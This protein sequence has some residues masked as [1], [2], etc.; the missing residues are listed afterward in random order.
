MD[1]KPLLPKGSVIVTT[2]ET[3]DTDSP[4]EDIDPICGMDVVPGRSKLV[5][6][7]KG[8]CYWFCAEASRRAFMADPNRYLK[9]IPGKNRGLV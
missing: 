8:H 9:Q 3:T 5:S 4:T 1:S 2:L 7:H 6:L